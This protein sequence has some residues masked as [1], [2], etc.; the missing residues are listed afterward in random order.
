MLSDCLFGQSPV[1]KNVQNSHSDILMSEQPFRQSHVW[2][3]T[4]WTAF[5]RKTCFL[6]GFIS[7]AQLQKLNYFSKLRF[8]CRIIWIIPA[9]NITL[10]SRKVLIWVCFGYTIHNSAPQ[11][12][13]KR[14]HLT[15]SLTN[16]RSA[17]YT[18]EVYF[19]LTFIDLHTKSGISYIML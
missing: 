13:N 5:S 6:A 3:D 2:P 10:V 12:T 17:L 19:L 16:E 14:G 8:L 18:I 4:D 1:S 9:N 7:S 15:N 11:G